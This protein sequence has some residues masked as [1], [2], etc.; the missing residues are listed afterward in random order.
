MTENPPSSPIG[1][2]SAHPVTYQQVFRCAQLAKP[3]Q[4]GQIRDA[5]HRYLVDVGED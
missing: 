3:R 2:A 4:S 5:T 1:E